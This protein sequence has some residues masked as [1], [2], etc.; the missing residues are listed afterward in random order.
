MNL[1]SILLVFALLA[2]SYSHGQNIEL[3]GTI[4]FTNLQSNGSGQ[5]L[6]IAA[7]NSSSIFVVGSS[8]SLVT[9]GEDTIKREGDYQPFILK[10]D[11]DGYLLEWAILPDELLDISQMF[12]YNNQ[13]GLLTS[14][15]DKNAYLVTL[16]SDLNNLTKRSIGYNIAEV[17][18][19]VIGSN[20]NFYITGFIRKS[21][22][23][24]N[25]TVESTDLGSAFVASYGISGDLQ[26]V[27]VVEDTGK[28][29]GLLMV[30]DYIYMTGYS[31]C[32]C[33]WQYSIL[34][35]K[36]S[37]EGEVVWA[38][39]YAQYKRA[40]G[41]YLQRTLSGGVTVMGLW[42]DDMYN[43]STGRYLGPSEERIFYLEIAS[44]GGYY[45]IRYFETDFT[46]PMGAFFP[47]KKGSFQCY[48]ERKY[49]SNSQNT[50]T[51]NITAS[52]YEDRQV[53]GVE[54]EFNDVILNKRHLIVGGKIN[55]NLQIGNTVLYPAN[56]SDIILLK[57]TYDPDY[58]DVIEK[59]DT[60][61]VSNSELV[62]RDTTQTVTDTEFLSDTTLI[63]KNTFEI[64]DR[65]LKTD[66]VIVTIMT[67]GRDTTKTREVSVALIN[68][69]SCYLFSLSDTIRVEVTEDEE[70][71]NN[72]NPSDS[73]VVTDVVMS[74]DA[75]NE[76]VYLYPNPTSSV[77]YLNLPAIY[78]D[79]EARIY[80][81]L[82][83]LEYK[84][85]WK[86]GK[87]VPISVSSLPK[88]IYHVGVMIDGKLYES[89]K[90]VKSQ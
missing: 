65:Y 50:Y 89:L 33:S 53:Q 35:S 23:F 72:D 1:K 14:G 77:V 75:E 22:S 59:S 11:E 79:V 56:K 44:S 88:G 80:N 10:I 16:D 4:N 78:N 24:D 27:Q 54:A 38:H 20:D 90:L 61:F 12:F 21:V 47:E 26:W 87:T 60:T 82:G 76:K 71:V 39:T 57:Y 37:A 43:L 67:M 31:S 18:D 46:K 7:N 42:E 36:L 84:K 13:V 34:V 52:R 29:L 70:T 15:E 69:D 73:P 81:Q 63:T 9:Y 32:Y 45:P 28:G 64:C 48:S 30:G 68:I 2:Y 51:F 3:V 25:E 19:L 74:V 41:Q 83:K 6:S 17:N 55:N 58:F 66:S 86:Y 40:Y 85:K 62:S 8:A 49:Y 5:L